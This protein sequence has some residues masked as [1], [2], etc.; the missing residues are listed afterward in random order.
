MI[1]PRRDWGEYVY[2][3]DLDVTLYEAT[4]RVYALVDVLRQIKYGTNEINC[5]GYNLLDILHP[6]LEAMLDTVG[7]DLDRIVRND[8][9]Y[10]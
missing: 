6:H 5:Q 7:D 10:E 3:S 8:E 4:T 2:Q 1:K 9:T